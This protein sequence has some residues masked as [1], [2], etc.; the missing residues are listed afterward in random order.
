MEEQRKYAILFA[1]K[2]LA[3]RKLNDIGSTPFTLMAIAGHVSRKMIEH[4]SHIRMEAK[5]AA[6]DAIAP[7]PTQA[8]LGQM[9]HKIGHSRSPS[10]LPGTNTEHWRLIP[11]MDKTAARVFAV[12]MLVAMSVFAQHPGTKPDKVSQPTPAQ[13][14]HRIRVDEEVQKAK[15]V[16][17]VSPV[18]PPVLGKR[19][20]GTVVL[21]VIV[22]KN[23]SVQSARAVSGLPSLRDSAVNAVLQWQYK[24][25]A[26]EW[27]VGRGRY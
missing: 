19:M 6:L 11:L 18:Y 25:N 15:L 16:R 24:P 14:P 26:G 17:V 3:A 8:V 21:H 10:C 5:R 20:D 13:Q 23:G 27:R 22:G 12:G 9:R 4:Y 2:I 7:Q 1:A